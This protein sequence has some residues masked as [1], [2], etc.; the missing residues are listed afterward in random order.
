MNLEVIETFFRY[1][2][3]IKK[4]MH[5]VAPNYMYKNDS[6]YLLS[7]SEQLNDALS[8]VKFYFNK[9]LDML[10]YS[11]ID[12]RYVESFIQNYQQ[13]LIK[14]NLEF[15]KLSKFYV[16]CFANI[17][18]ELI[19]KVNSEC[20]GYSVNDSIRLTEGKTVNEILHIIHQSVINN[21]KVY[22]SMPVLNQKYNMEGYPITLYGHNYGIAEKIFNYF[23]TNIICGDTDIL[24]LNNKILIMVRDR[25]HALMIEIEKEDKDE[26]Y[27]VK[28]FI[29]KICN[30]EMVNSLK[31]VR[32]V[33]SNYGYTNG[34]FECDEQSLPY[35]LV[36]FISK[37]PTDY[38]I[39]IKT[40]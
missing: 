12:K 40:I 8:S 20:I 21:E 39:N 38:D 30:M 19:N 26:I 7:Y 2:L 25:G 37:V 10:N 29:P 27:Y 22:K 14:I 34:V 31:G 15:D 13:Q 9:M 23:P 5:D 33:N 28:Y 24:S 3:K 17:S 6:E 1:D 35:E 16:S 11:D 4:I 36:T 18:D 32:K